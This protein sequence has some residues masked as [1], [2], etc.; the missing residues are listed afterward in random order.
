MISKNHKWLFWLILA[1]YSTFF[2]EV[3][4]GSDMF[5]F[6]N[7]WGMLV[8]LP[9]YGLHTIILATIIFRY[10]KP[11]LSTL[12]FAGMLF[13]LYEA[14]MTKVLWKPSW[15]A[16]LVLGDVAVFEVFV[17]VFWWHTWF[18]FIAPLILGERLFTSSHFV[19][20]G[21]PEGLLHF[22]SG[23]KGYL[24]LIIFGGIFQSINSPS[25]EHSLLSGLSSIGFL[26][27]LTWVW[28]KTT[29]EKEYTLPELLPDK[30]EFCF[31]AIWLA[32]LYLF[33]GFGIYPERLPGIVGQGIIW[34]FYILVITLLIRALR[35]SSQ[36]NHLEKHHP[37]TSKKYWLIIWV[38][39]VFMLVTAKAFLGS[40]ANFIVLGSWFIGSLISVI[41][42]FKAIKGI[43]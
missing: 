16:S 10:G 11:T 23:W 43:R 4:A 12:V 27:L 41:F 1:A 37:I 7:I 19:L 24:T 15:E 20:N 29:K 8:V 38:V 13:G 32:I 5:P 21:L 18:S 35:V 14:Y 6:F 31:L 25:V 3:F 33:L 28:K 17:L 26:V 22:F 36:E 39:F 2:A 30:K 42:F 40:V 9:I 34:A